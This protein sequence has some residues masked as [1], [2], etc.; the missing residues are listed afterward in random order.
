MKHSIH[1]LMILIFANFTHAQTLDYRRLWN[2]VERYE[3]EGLIQSALKEVVQI[4]KLAIKDKNTQQL[5]K[6]TLF[7]S[8]FALVLMEDAQ[9]K[10]INDLE[11]RIVL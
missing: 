7:K 2:K 5:I 8:K 3:L 9:L 10:I 11:E 4:E 1:I 6:T